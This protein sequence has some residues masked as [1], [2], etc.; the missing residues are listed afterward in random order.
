MTNPAKN[1]CVFGPTSNPAHHTSVLHFWVHE[2]QLE[3]LWA[4]QAPFIKCNYRGTRGITWENSEELWRSAG[5]CGEL[6]RAYSALWELLASRRLRMKSKEMRG[7]CTDARF[8]EWHLFLDGAFL[9]LFYRKAPSKLYKILRPELRVRRLR[10][11]AV[12]G[13]TGML[14]VARHVTS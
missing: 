3:A 9:W 10:S 11:V 8:R 13:V 5:I 14:E 12:V 1:S 4:N 7:H 2:T 6:W